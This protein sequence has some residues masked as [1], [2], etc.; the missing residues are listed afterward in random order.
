MKKV[1][2]NAITFLINSRNSEGLWSDFRVP[3]ESDEWVSAYIGNI[4]ASAENEE[5]MIMARKAWDIFGSR[6]V[7]TGNGGWGYNR[8]APEDA[9]STAWGI[10]FALKIGLKGKLRTKMAENFLLKHVTSDGGLATYILEKDVR[11]LLHSLPEDD[12]SGWM[13]THPCIT[14]AAA[15][16]PSFN[17]ILVP[18]LI[19][20]QLADGSWGAYW[21]SDTIYTTAY[22]VEALI[23][24]GK[25]KHRSSI[26]KAMEWIVD[27]FGYKNYFSNNLFPFGSPFATAL[28]LRSMALTNISE[29]FLKKMEEVSNWLIDRQQENGSWQASTTMLFPKPSMKTTYNFGEMAKSELHPNIL[30]ILDQNSLFTT[31]TVLDSLLYY[32]KLIST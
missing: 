25:E 6:N 24:N 21:C 31:A 27:K 12:I 29:I 3:R 20:N 14:A 18:Y 8:F 9:D 16:L 32:N 23:I 26:D 17:E 5:A 7:F 11:K 30:I 13:G 28:A 22:A 2:Q 15:V 19:D 4:L 1:I 10:K